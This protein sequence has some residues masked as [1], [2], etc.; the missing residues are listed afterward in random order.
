MRCLFVVPSL[1]RAG[2]E[3]QL[4]ALVNGLAQ[5]GGE[6]HLLAFERELDQRERLHRDIRFHHSSSTWKYDVG[7]TRA[8]GSVIDSEKIE[9]VHATLQF[10]LLAAWLGR[11]Q[12]SATPPLIATIHTTISRDGKEECLNKLIYRRLMRRCVTNVFVCEK[13]R[14]YWLD[15]YPELAASSRV[16]Y[17]GIDVTRFQFVDYEIAGCDFRKTEGIP[18]DAVVFGCIA[19]FRPEK[20]HDLL[21]RAFRDVAENAFLLLA[22][23]GERMQEMRSLARSLGIERRVKFLGEVQDPRPV[24]AACNVTVL[25]STAVET[26]SMAMLES[27]AMGVPVIAPDI[28]GLSEAVLDGKTGFLFPAGDIEALSAALNL[29]KKKPQ[30]I[31]RLGRESS[32]LVREKFSEEEMISRTRSLLKEGINR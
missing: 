14:T 22:G 17:N 4:I 23:A 26:F 19:G 29:A 3:T 25:A 11:A 8:I 13:Q 1:R 6:I 21:L 9:V 30:E 16:V 27:M 31:K 32:R 15:K 20:G 10:A 12:A 2:A 5:R 18:G 28:G 24:I 7:F